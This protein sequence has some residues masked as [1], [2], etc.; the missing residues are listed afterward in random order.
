MTKI[1]ATAIVASGAELGVDVEIGAYSIVGPQVKIGDRTRI[2][3]Q[4]FLDGRTTIG[5]ECAI[6]PFASIG[7]QTQD[8]KFKGGTTY[9]EIGDQT[10]LREYVT[11]NS[12]TNEGDVTRV[13]SRCHILAYSHV[14]HQCIIGNEVIMSNAT[15][16]GGHVIVEDGVGI[17][18]MCGVHQFVRIGT[19]SFIGACSKVTQDI[20]PYMLADG[21][22]AMPHGINIVGLQRRNVSEEVRKMLKD[23]YKILYRQNLT[24]RQAFELIKTDI[25]VCAER[26]RLVAFVEASERGIAR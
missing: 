26:D 25:P 15:N 13:G 5:A 18:G 4:V 14:A 8:L 20:P 3:P 24:T 22:P 6:F 7:S 2:M 12:G 9:V 1:H 11:V 17:G 19:M 16:L 10:T 23:A 21:N